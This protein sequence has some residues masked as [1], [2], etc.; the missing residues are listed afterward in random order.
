MSEPDQESSAVKLTRRVVPKELPE[1]AGCSELL[2]RIVAS[3]G[4]SKTTELS[5]ALKDLLP[6]SSLKDIEVATER[7]L[8]ALMAQQRVLIVGDFDADGATAT[9]LSIRALRSVGFNY[10][11]YIVPN[12]F[13]YGYGLTPQIIEVAK[14]YNPQLIITVDNG[15]SSVE[16]VDYATQQGVD[17]IVTDHHLP[18]NNLP[19]AA[20]IVNPNQAG[21]SFSSKNLAGVGVVFY[22][23]LAFKQTLLK[24]DYFQQNQLPVPNLVQWLDLV[25]L[26]TVADV[27]VLDTNNRILVEQGLRRIRSGQCSQGILALLRLGKKDYRRTCSQDLGFVCGPRLNAAGRLDDMSLGI[28]CLLADSAATAHALA[29]ELDTMNSKRRELES[30][31]KQCALSQLDSIALDPSLLPPIICLYDEEWHQGIVGIIAARIRERYYRPCLVF[32]PGTEGEIKGSGRSIPG[33]HMRDVID[34]VA[35]LHPGVVEK[36][37]GHAMAAGLSIRKQDYS[38]FKSAV[39]AVADELTNDTTFKEEILSDGAL[40]RIH[41]NLE[42]ARE[43]AQTIPWGQGFPVPIFDDEFQIVERHVLKQTHL[44]LQL[45]PVGQQSALNAIAFNVDMEKWPAIGRKV[46]LLY[47]LSVNEYN[48]VSSLQLIVQRLL[49]SN[50]YVQD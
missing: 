23:M 39:V 42:V 8:E 12:R 27:V 28:E 40:E 34:R 1:L 24:L 49:S 30:G 6:V 19:A 17:V 2:K 21:D 22:L 29:A 36:F 10:V 35:T 45:R 9:A 31:M 20:A 4:V 14:P 5:S 43:L 26:G 38:H 46:H 37:G 16:G 44:K 3:R 13:E 50:I 33:V 7:L 41:Y 48:G 32:A 11:D 25:A 18:G 15:I 47:Q